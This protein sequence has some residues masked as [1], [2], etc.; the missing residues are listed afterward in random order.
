M[1][2]LWVGTV[3]VQDVESP[4]AL[5]RRYRSKEDLLRTLCHA[6][7]VESGHRPNRVIITLDSSTPLLACGPRRAARPPTWRCRSGRRVGDREVVV[8]PRVEAGRRVQ[9]VAGERAARWQREERGKNR[10]G[11]HPCTHGA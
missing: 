7:Y 6:L 4:L 11:E 5:Y 10:T 3:R 2:S 9:R 1:W 8:R